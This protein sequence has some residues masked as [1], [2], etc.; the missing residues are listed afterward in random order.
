MCS[1]DLMIDE[2]HDPNQE[3]MAQGVANF[4][5]PF[6]GGI[7]VTGTIA[8]TVTNVRSG[9]RS[10]LAGIFH[11]LTL[12]AVVLLAAPLA[13]DIP[14]AT[15]AG[16][17][18]FVAWNMAEWRAF[19]QLKQF[20]VNY[21]IVMLATFL[22]TVIFDLTVAVEVGL[23]LA[24]LFFIVRIASVTRIEP[25]ELPP[26]AESRL[27][28]EGWRI[29]GS[30][31][32]GSVNRLEPLLDP[33][34]QTADVMILD[35]HQLINLDTTGLDA[36]QSLHRALAKHGERLIIVGANT[37]PLSLMERAGFFAAAGEDAFF[38]TMEEAL[39]AL[40]D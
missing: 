9:A 3:L 11:A 26:V 5:A 7:A 33:A 16:I 15:L 23:V 31:F 36:L 34:R 18:L 20:T 32:F 35:L 4:V 1:S 24:S 37:Q 8:R 12:L 21:R 29:F 40:G 22:L 19:P 17:L 6:F 25:I 28:V 14:L 39:Q 27:R 30:L 13:N 2:R 10:P 38:G